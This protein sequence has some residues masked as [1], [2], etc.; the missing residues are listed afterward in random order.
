MSSAETAGF[1]LS[2]QQQQLWL[3]G[4]EWTAA[5]SQ[6]A[7][8]LP[9]S[10]GDDDVRSAVA[11]VVARHEAL[12][13]LFRRRAGMRHPS[14]LV[15]ET[16]EPGWSV[17]QENGELTDERIA[18]LLE[19]E[20]A[21]PA[22]VEQGPVVQA[23]LV[24][25][26]SSSL[27]VLS[28][29]GACADARSLALVARELC[30]LLGLDSGAALADDPLQYADY[31]EWRNGLLAEDE[32]EAAEGRRH[33]DEASPQ[34][35]PRVLF[36]R[37]AAPTDPAS[38]RAV[39]VPLDPGDVVRGAAAG[40]VSEP[41]FVE[42]C[43]HACLARLSGEAEP[44][45]LVGTSG[46]AHEDLLD[47]VGGFSTQL[48]ARASVESTVTM[49]E[50]VDRTKR[51]RSLVE[52]FA[53]Y[54]DA[55]RLAAVFEPPAVAFAA[56]ELPALPGATLRACV[57]R[58]GPLALELVW[59]T[60]G[61]ERRAELRYD[62]AV[63]DRSDAEQAAQHLAQIVAQSA[64]DPTL[65][66]EELAL[67]TDRPRDLAAGRSS[68]PDAV[69][70][71]LFEQ[72]AAAR[73]D[74]VAVA[75]GDVSL[76]YEELDA[77]A[78]R[79]A[80]R[81]VEHG[82]GPDVPVG[83]CMDRSVDAIVG[84]LAILKAGGAYV[85]LN[86]E[87]PPARLLHQ[88]EETGA[89]V[90]V[91][92][93]ALLERLPE[94]A[95]AV[96]CVDREADAASG[97]GAEN[98]DV[99]VRPENLV[100]VM[101]T[102][103]STGQPKGV[104]VTHRNLAGYAAAI[105]ERLL[106]GADEALSFATVTSLSTDLGTTSVFAALTSGGRLELVPPEVAMDGDAF[107]AYCAARPIDVLK[108]TP[109][110]LRA[111][112]AGTDA[113]GTKARLPRRWL[114]CGGEALS[115]QLVDT[116]VA[117]AAECRVLNHYGPTETT[118]GACAYEVDARAPRLSATVPVGRSLAHVRAAVL[119]SRLRLLPPGVPG[120]LCI[121]GEGVARGYLGQ[122]EQ[123][124]AVFVPDPFADGEA[125]LYRTGDRA[126][127]LPDDTIEF[128]GRLDAQVKVRGYRVEPGEI[129]AALL[130]HPK[131]T[132]AAVAAVE[133]ADGEL[134]LV[135]YVVSSEQ[136]PV[137]EL[138]ALL[139]ESLPAYMVPTRFVRMDALPFT[140]SGKIDRRALPD[141][142]QVES[143][144][145]YVAPRTPLEEGLAQIWA[146]LLGVERVGV[147]DDFF[148]LGG[149]SLLAT[150]VVIRIR[151]AYTDIP[152]HSLFDF[153]TV[154]GLAEVVL[155]RELAAEVPADAGAGA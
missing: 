150:Q 19:A 71:E 94:L 114:V 91:T 72:R 2:P 23:L 83:L 3:L 59:T 68:A 82:V 16:L 14:Q 42:A 147:H 36:A 35:G 33:W 26:P 131:V 44:A 155:E 53:D 95:C 4:P 62:P 32:P 99:D 55:D 88:L 121:G 15:Q 142:A 46:R 39:A 67:E 152:L 125:R 28:V 84:L 89:P 31:A 103:G 90:L 112:L 56:L 38:W 10:C 127:F 119:D 37:D 87:H 73:P 132:Q 57:D 63:V 144:R 61:E 85:P 108:I 126:R 128:L 45:V 79:L 113:A 129:E 98:L 149:H 109:S 27:L 107:A 81:L 1:R 80:R 138:Q 77:A 52:R 47:A 30:V 154:A 48:S 148:A 21:Q 34:A 153:P 65:A 120:E 93:E 5:W 145:A 11:Q 92:Q 24:R 64:Q 123:T 66:V 8:E 49:A 50:L 110:H 97:S 20:A 13:T 133:G 106:E 41:I 60:A 122:P 69:V 104:A 54:A 124:A 43:W 58:P 7:V 86:F 143:E 70:H 116:I 137:E 117:G 105:R 102:S 101:Y 136:P 139:R 6:C 22:D 118:V 130:A 115:W 25:A 140:G 29:A 151:N 96:V 134:M 78:N 18:E 40:R 146:E 75:A 141:P 51:L 9:A 74:A 100:Y 76:T 135:A 17:R 111:L 12:R